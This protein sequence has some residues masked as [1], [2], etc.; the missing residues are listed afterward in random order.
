MYSRSTCRKARLRRPAVA[1]GTLLIAAFPAGGFAGVQNIKLVFNKTRKGY[2]HQGVTKGPGAAW[3]VFNTRNIFR[4]ESDDFSTYQEGLV[5]NMSTV[6]HADFKR[7]RL[8]HLGAPE[9][10]DGKVYTFAKIGAY[11]PMRLVW[12][13]AADLSYKPG[14]FREI[15]IPTAPDGRNYAVSGGPHIVGG[16][17]YSALAGE[18]KYSK[19]V[20]KFRFPTAEL[21][22]FIELTRPYYR[23]QGMDMDRDGNF[24]IVETEGGVQQYASSGVYKGVLYCNPKGAIHEGFHFEAERQR[25]VISYDRDGHRVL[26]VDGDD[27][28]YIPGQGDTTPPTA[29]QALTAKSKGPFNAH[30]KWQRATDPDSGVGRYGIYRNGKMIATTDKMEYLD[31]AQVTEC[32][33]YTYEVV[34]LNGSWVGSARSNAATLTSGPD[35]TPPAALS[36]VFNAKARQL[37]VLFDEPVDEQSAS[38]VENYAIDGR[39]AVRA[40]R[41]ES[42][43]RTIVLSVSPPEPL[44]A[45]HTL[46]I[47]DV[48]DRAKARSRVAVGTQIRFRADG[49]VGHWTFDAVED[50]TVRDASGMGHDAILD[51]AKIAPGKEGNALAL[52]G[53]GYAIVPSLSDIRFPGCG[54]L[55]FWVK[56]DFAGQD[57]RP[58]FGTGWDARRSHFF[59]RVRKETS[60]GNLQIA[61]QAPRGPYRFAAYTRVASNAWNEIVISWD[62]TN[63]TASVHVNG[64][65]ARKGPLRAWTPSGQDVVFG[66]GFTGLIDDVRLYSTVRGQPQGATE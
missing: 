40:A 41:L 20:A 7:S 26:I 39:T 51:N 58:L 52:D 60:R 35:V 17:F 45:P 44:D 5:R 27:L 10:H 63:R 31:A 30:L 24:Y 37:S 14:S 62:C 32:T 11:P 23:P 56:G 57:N 48:T 12:F 2:G 3:F 43:G 61:F 18:D 36:A 29:P 59:A 21:V 4:Y 65:L 8:D 38:R 66:K 15:T 54:T 53:R 46:T 55:N 13:D 25:L 9:Y 42:G 1:L 6:S 19:Y 64:K 50:G 22:E 49:L 16:Y 28:N 47:R 34:A 33:R